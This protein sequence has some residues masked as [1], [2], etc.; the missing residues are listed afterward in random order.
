MPAT[1]NLR[2]TNFAKI[3]L[4]E[5]SFIWAAKTISSSRDMEMEVGWSLGGRSRPGP[6]LSWPSY[7]LLDTGRRGPSRFCKAS[8]K[9][10]LAWGTIAASRGG[11]AKWWKPT[12]YVKEDDNDFQK[13]FCHTVAALKAEKEEAFNGLDKDSVYVIKRVVEKAREALTTREIFHSDF[14]T[15]PVVENALLALK[16]LSDIEVVV[17]GGYPE[18]ER[19][20]LAVGHADVM[21]SAPYAA[22]ALRISGNFSFDPASH[23]DF[24]GAVLGTGIKREKI[25]DILL[26]DMKGA[27]II[28]V[29]EL[30]DYLVSSVTQ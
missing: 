26:Q 9:P 12:H 10:W 21:S 3:S 19:C 16:N 27:Q 14:L 20:R 1:A 8:D 6:F 2:L 18:A 15:P 30:V 25:G 28:V 5:R 11:E 4:E 17:Q 13:G 23:G 24:V 29:P 22:A 7:T